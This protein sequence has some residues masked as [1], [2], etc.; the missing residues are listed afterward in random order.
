MHTV[1]NQHNPLRGGLDTYLEETLKER[2]DVVVEQS[3]EPF[4][5]E[6]PRVEAVRPPPGGAFVPRRAKFKFVHDC[7]PIGVVRPFTRRWLGWPLQRS[8]EAQICAAAAVDEVLRR[9]KARR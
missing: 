4:R 3:G 6:R 8:A 1:R 2:R 7:R 9:W 5:R